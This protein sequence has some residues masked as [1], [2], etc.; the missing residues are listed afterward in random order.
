[1]ESFG[2]RIGDAFDTPEE[3]DGETTLAGARIGNG[4]LA[5]GDPVMVPV[6]AGGKVRAVCAG[7][8][9]VSF[10]NREWRAVSITGLTAAD[11]MLGGLAE[12]A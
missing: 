5:I 8:P 3:F 1:M 7:L 12:R 9:L 11:V 4:D 10:S 2:F 6:R